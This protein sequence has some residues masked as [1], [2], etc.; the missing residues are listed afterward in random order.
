MLPKIEFGHFYKFIA[1][2]GLVMMGVAV[3]LPWLIFQQMAP[4]VI[5]ESDLV[6]YTTLAQQTISE[7]QQNLQWWAENQLGISLLTFLAGVAVTL[8]GLQGWKERQ[9]V[10]DDKEKEELRSLIAAAPASDA[11]V[12]QRLEN[13][14]EAAIAET[15]EREKAAKAA[16]EDGHVDSAT[17]P[18]ST[19]ASKETGTN[20]VS[21]PESRRS[22]ARLKIEEYEGRLGEILTATLGP[23]HEVT[24]N[25]RLSVASP[26]SSSPIHDVVAIPRDKRLPAYVFD[27]KV[28]SHIFPGRITESAV[29]MAADIAALPIADRERVFGCVVFIL[30]NEE[31]RR[32]LS[33]LR[34]KQ[35]IDRVR[36]V[37]ERPVGIVLL[38]EEEFNSLPYDDLSLRV[39]EDLMSSK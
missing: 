35:E 5:K 10:T 8:H 28:I 27:I 29:R 33:A 13:E 7:R 38:S 39:L 12:S 18:A 32:T 16:S 20:T 4:L 9:Q 6:Q 34:A 19:K 1:S 14:V 3:A 31:D 2:L 24:R 22:E 17:S 11:E 36:A 23:T 26:A 25:A 30:R 15:S 21:S 37:L